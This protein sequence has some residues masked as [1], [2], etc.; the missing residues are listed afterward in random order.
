MKIIN[1]NKNN[2]TYGKDGTVYRGTIAMTRLE[3]EKAIDYLKQEYKRAMKRTDTYKRDTLAF[4]ARLKEINDLESLGVT[5]SCLVV[6]HFPCMGRM[7]AGINYR[8]KIIDS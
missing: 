4:I 1:H 2:A 7:K 8:V 3:L 6:T 5:G